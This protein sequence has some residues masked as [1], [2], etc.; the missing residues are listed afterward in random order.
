M[1]RAGPKLH[2]R[3]ERKALTMI[4]PCVVIFEGGGLPPTAD[5][6]EQPPDEVRRAV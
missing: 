2:S 1:E 5:V 4:E 3:F 6:R